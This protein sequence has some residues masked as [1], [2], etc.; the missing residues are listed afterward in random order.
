[1]TRHGCFFTPAAPPAARRIPGLRRT[2]YQAV[3]ATAAIGITVTVITRECS[4][5]PERLAFLVRQVPVAAGCILVTV[6]SPV[7]PI[8]AAIITGVAVTAPAVVVVVPVIAVPPVIVVPS[9][10]KMMT[11]I[12]G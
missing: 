8:A 9:P 1:M 12:K 2:G 6:P 4:L 10:V 5:V 7:T 11:V 3:F